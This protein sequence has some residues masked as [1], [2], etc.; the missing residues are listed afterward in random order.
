VRSAVSDLLVTSLLDN[1]GLLLAVFINHVR[2]PN[3]GNYYPESYSSETLAAKFSLETRGFH[4][5]A[6]RLFGTYCK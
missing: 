1:S 4:T 6:K 2:W 3:D 5:E